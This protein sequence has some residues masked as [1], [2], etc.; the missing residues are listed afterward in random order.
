[1]YLNVSCFFKRNDKFHCQSV[2]FS[3]LVL[4]VSQ[5]LR[6]RKDP[7]KTAVLVF[8]IIPAQGKKSHIYFLL[9]YFVL[10]QITFEFLAY[11]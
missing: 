3:F 5:N 10:A 8:Y 1:M 4:S 2:V 6:I 11:S 9:L 7:Q